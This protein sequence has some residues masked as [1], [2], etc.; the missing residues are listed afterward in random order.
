MGESLSGF[1]F[2][3][4]SNGFYFSGILSGDP[5]GFFLEDFSDRFL[6]AFSLVAAAFSWNLNLVLLPGAFAVEEDLDLFSSSGGATVAPLAW[7]FTGDDSLGD[8]RAR[9]HGDGV[10]SDRSALLAFKVK[11]DVTVVV[12]LEATSGLVFLLQGAG[13][14]ATVVGDDNVLSWAVF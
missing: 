3:G 10:G 6:L 7:G 4:N 1:L 9:A 13:F 8:A 12:E 11:S 5:V 2:S 14:D